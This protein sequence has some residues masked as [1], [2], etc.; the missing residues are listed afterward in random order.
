MGPIDLDEY[1]ST[2]EEEEARE[3]EKA[4]EAEKA[5]EKQRTRHS[6]SA[7]HS[8]CLMEPV[9]TGNIRSGKAQYHEA[10]RTTKTKT[11]QPPFPKTPKHPD[12]KRD[13][14]AAPN[15]SRILTRN[16]KGGLRKGGQSAS[17][18]K[19]EDAEIPA[20]FANP[21]REVDPP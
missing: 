10:P 12:D 21:T 19:D 8:L 20:L 15:Q 18:V 6:I 1:M 16:Q 2:D 17:V 14:G 7:S 11:N 13:D 9:T 3:V 5:L 4:S